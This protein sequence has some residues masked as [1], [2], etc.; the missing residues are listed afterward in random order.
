[1]IRL[2]DRRILREQAP[3]PIAA[4]PT[5]KGKRV[6][7]AP[8]LPPP[9]DLIGALSSTDARVRRRAALAVGRVGLAEGVA[10]LAQL[11]GRE[12]DPEVRQ[13]AAFALGLIGDASAAHPLATALRDPMPLVQGRA[14]EALGMIGATGQASAIAGMMRPHVDA[15][16]LRAITPDDLTYPMSPEIEAVRLG[17]YALA[18]LK[19]Y[20]A[21]ASVVLDGAGQPVTEWWPIAYALGRSDDPRAAQAL[22]VLTR[23]AGLYT[24]AFAARGLGRVKAVEAVPALVPLIEDLA[25]QPLVALEAIRAVGELNAR[26]A[27]PVLVAL[28]RRPA[29]DPGVR[30]EIIASLGRVGGTDDGERLLDLLTDPAPLVRAAAFRALGALDHQRFLTALSGLEPDREWSVRAAVAGA[31]GSVAPEQAVPLLLPMLRDSDQRVL[32]AVL[33]ALV[34]A[35]APEADRIVIE[36]LGVEDVVVRSAAAAALGELRPASGP[37]AL[38]AAYAAA[39][40]DEMYTAR[41]AII[42]ALA[43]YGRDAALPTLSQ[44]LADKDWAVRRRAASL[45]NT[46]DPARNAATEIRPA[47]ATFDAATIASDRIVAPPYSTHVYLETDRGTIQIELA[48]LD[49]PL[50]VHSFVTLARKGYFDGLGIHRAVPGFVVQDGDPRGDGEG[51]PG[52]TLRDEINERPYLRG[53]VGM[54]LDGPDTGGSQYFITHAPQ[55]HLDG[56]YTVFGQVI[57]GMEV[58]DQLRQG[59][60]V[61]HVR[62][63]D[64]TQ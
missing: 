4:V 7:A 38:A 48:V 45:L 20:E 34:T 31:L 56:R 21:L 5:T 22:M 28:V 32:P 55:P 60:V 9:P 36:H 42:D 1:V 16:I 24:R 59:D 8:S 3:A 6:A 25:R 35:K 13:M 40:R 2:E 10:P 19:A 44:A 14:A 43:K 52:Y 53:T 46:L 64:G 47:P 11:L 62:V 41:V 15:G 49:A 37:A 61:R 29:L 50:T 54:A 39:Q 63:W 23:S 27:S 51:G 58:L 17:A 12:G 18:R 26:A 30:A 33:Q 57:A